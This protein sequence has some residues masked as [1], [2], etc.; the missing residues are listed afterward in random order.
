MIAK[1]FSPNSSVRLPMVFGSLLRS[2]RSSRS[3]SLSSSLIR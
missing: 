2:Q 1:L 3:L